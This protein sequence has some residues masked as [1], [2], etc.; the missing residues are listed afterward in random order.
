MKLKKEIWYIRTRMKAHAKDIVLPAYSLVISDEMLSNW[1]ANDSDVASQMSDEGLRA[2]LLQER[3]T[4]LIGT[5]ERKDLF[6][7]YGRGLV[8]HIFHLKHRLSVL[9]QLLQRS[10]TS[11]KDLSSTAPSGT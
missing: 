5:V 3:V 11:P 10:V 6:F 1:R 2:K 9:T 7:I 8:R 4:G